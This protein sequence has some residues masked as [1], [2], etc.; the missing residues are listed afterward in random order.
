MGSYDLAEDHPAIR[1]F[2]ASTVVV[3]ATTAFCITPLLRYVDLDW[4]VF[5]GFALAVSASI[6]WSAMRNGWGPYWEWPAMGAVV[7]SLLSGTYVVTRAMHEAVDNDIRCLHVQEDM[8]MPIPRRADGPDLFQALG[9]RPQGTSD[10]QFPKPKVLPPITGAG[11]PFP[12]KAVS[13]KA[14]AT[15]PLNAVVPKG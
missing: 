2:V 1:T 6:S 12:Q 4:F 9:C 10:I 11:Q 7:I 8:L 15:K 13:P 14:A 3:S 5:A